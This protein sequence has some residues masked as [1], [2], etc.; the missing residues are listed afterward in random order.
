MI[1]RSVNNLD[2]SSPYSN[3][4][5]QTALGAASLPIKNINAFQANW[6]I[7]IGKTGEETAEIVTL[8]TGSPSGTALS[9]SGT[10]RFSHPTDTPVYAIKYDQVIFARSI[11]GTAGTVSDMV[12]GTVNI[13][14]D[15]PYTQIDDSQG[16]T[17]YAYKA[18]YRNSVMGVGYDS[19]ESDWITSTGYSPYS[20]ARMRERIK[21]KLISSNYI[22]SD[23]II[24]D[25]INEWLEK[26][27][28]T[29][30]DVNRDYLLGEESIV[31]SSGQ[32]MGTITST[33][34]KELRRMR[35]VTPSGT[36]T[37]ARMNITDFRADQVFTESLPQFYWMGDK[38]FGRKP[39]D[40]AATIQLVYYKTSPIL[41]NDAD[42][43]PTSM[44]NYSKSFIDY[45]Y[46]QACFLDQKDDK[47]YA[48]INMANAELA[49]F[50]QE[51][52]PR[53]KTGIQYV[54]IVSP[55]SS[56]DDFQMI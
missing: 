10:T 20:L 11:T 43:I 42:E 18:R 37:A 33:D 47:G 31:M 29:A 9:L 24:N 50:K 54:T 40:N 28:N 8:G 52:A 44:Q 6:A 36:A 49:Q 1:I 39:T 13:T 14:P 55:L 30:I 27:T 48:F 35:I 45:G 4:S 34:F 56:E 19:P 2:V 5:S 15:A 51:I 25:W 38:V 53:W 23:E 26:M 3:I 12:D 7:Q 41:V 22:Q 46:A 16:S 32:E 21:R 17:T